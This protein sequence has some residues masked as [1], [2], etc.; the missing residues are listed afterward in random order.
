MERNR[1]FINAHSACG[2]GKWLLVRPD[3]KLPVRPFTAKRRAALDPKESAAAS[4]PRQ[5][6][7]E[8]GDGPHR[9]TR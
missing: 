9:T 5:A 8:P 7:S 6:G 1:V 3:P 4:R 2:G